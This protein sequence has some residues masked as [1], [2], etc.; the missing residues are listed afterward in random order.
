MLPPQGCPPSPQSGI[1]QPPR[2]RLQKRQKD[3]K[4]KESGCVITGEIR[5]TG[6]QESPLFN[7]PPIDG[8][9]LPQGAPAST[10]SS[11]E[12]SALFPRVPFKT[13]T[14]PLWAEWGRRLTDARRQPES[15]RASS[16]GE[17]DSGPEQ[18]GRAERR[19]GGWL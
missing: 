4:E 10:P 16:A 6:R 7:K 18:C 9:A 5:L 19:A 17:R 3:E 2:G 14:V 13:Q 11:E 8:L 15:S 12:S 1:A